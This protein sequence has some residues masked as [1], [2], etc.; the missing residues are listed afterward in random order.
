MENTN[1]KITA[2][3][4]GGIDSANAAETES[5]IMAQ[6][7]IDADISNLQK[8]IDFVGSRLDVAGC[9]LKPKMQLDLAVEE[10]F[11][12][13]AKYAYAPGKGRVTVRVE[14]SDNPVTAS[15][16]F[17]DNGTP[18]DPLKKADPDVT[19]S[20]NDRQ[21]GGLGVFM[22]KKITDGISYEHKNGQNI[23]TL[24]KTIL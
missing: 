20:A 6:L 4:S 17:I 10:I 14:V 15:V 9:P 5:S 24:K 2:A 12:N 21:I 16:T 13:I 1:K 8:V 7:E 18:Y 11:V 22:T 19:L 3:L 23:L